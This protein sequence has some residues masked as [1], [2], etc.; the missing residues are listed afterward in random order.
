MWDRRKQDSLPSQPVTPASVPPQ[1]A[2][3]FA[4]SRTV[5][6][7]RRSGATIGKAVRIVG[8]VYSE[9]DLFID[10][11]VQGTLEVRNSK[12]TIGPN[13]K[14][15]SDIRAREVVIQGQ[16]Q[17]NVEAL[18]KINIRK[19]G[20]LVGNI[21]TAGIIIE[22]DAYF[23]GSIDIVRNANEAASRAPAQPAPQQT[24]PQSTEAAAVKA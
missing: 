18:Q 13:G 6:P 3:S 10:G 2:Q 20:S 8:D 24:N 15:K 7:E 9:E 4:S 21:R 12:V 14:A 17:G 11:E 19:E 1:P 23:K 22:D 16:V 5:E